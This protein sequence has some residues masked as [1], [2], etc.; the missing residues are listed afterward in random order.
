[1]LERFVNCILAD[2]HTD[3]T[4]PLPT[5]STKWAIRFC[6]RQKVILRTEVPK[7]AKRQAIED[8]VLIKEWFDVLGRDIEKYV[9]QHEDIYNIDELGIY[10]GQG[11]K[12]KV[13]II[14]NKA[15][16]C[17][18]GKVFSCESVMITETICTNGHVILPLII[19]KG[20]TY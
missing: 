7:E 16:W 9:V 4:K 12:E 10:I 17:E 20:K 6:K 2:R 8:L 13:F 11:K 19:F 5:C 3:P 18:A 15:A 1:M 14:H